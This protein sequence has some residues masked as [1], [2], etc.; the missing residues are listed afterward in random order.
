ME[1][2]RSLPR[3]SPHHRVFWRTARGIVLGEVHPRPGGDWIHLLLAAA[4]P[5]A[6]LFGRLYDDVLDRTP[7]PV[8]P[9]T[10]AAAVR[11]LA[12]PPGRL[13][14]IV[15]WE[16]VTHPPAVLRARLT[17]SPGQDIGPVH[18]SGSRAG[19]LVVTAETPADAETLAGDLA[20]S[21]T[22]TV[23]EPAPARR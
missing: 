2:N 20:R 18:D 14:G 21:V 16:R 4:G 9:A 8:P 5:G 22:F 23:T 15:G 10:G 11:F 7:T 3:S 1:R 13:E 17:V 6:D 19:Y 12:P